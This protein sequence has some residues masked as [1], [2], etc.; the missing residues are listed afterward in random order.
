MGSPQRLLEQSGLESR[1]GIKMSDRIIAIYHL[2]GSSN[3]RRPI[4]LSR[5]G[6]AGL[7]VELL[8]NCP[9]S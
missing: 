6:F 4:S 2:I 1:G 3:A 9:Q 5:Y 7:Q 8:F